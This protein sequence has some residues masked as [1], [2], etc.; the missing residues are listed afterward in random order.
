MNSS[1]CTCINKI[2]YEDFFLFFLI[3]FS[4]SFCKYYWNAILIYNTPRQSLHKIFCPNEQIASHSNL[5]E[6]KR[7]LLTWNNWMIPFIHH[8]QKPYVYLAKAYLR[9]SLFSPCGSKYLDYYF[10]RIALINSSL[11]NS[12]LWRSSICFLCSLF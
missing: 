8:C 7:V 2:F 5:C 12:S 3:Y 6:E 1:P 9:K 4:Y 10:S 11:A